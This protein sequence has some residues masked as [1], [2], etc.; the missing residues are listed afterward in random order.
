MKQTLLLVAF[1]VFGNMLFS[2]AVPMALKDW[3]TN[4]GTQTMF[5]KNVVKTD[6]SGNVYTAGAT[7]NA[8]G[9]YDILLT[10]VTSGGT[11][12]YTKTV[13]GTANEHDF[14]LGMLV[15]GT[16]VFITGAIT[17][18]TTTLAPDLF[19]AKYNSSGVQ[20]FFTTFSN[21]YG[22]VGRDIVINTTHNYI[23][24]SGA[25]YDNTLQAD[26]LAVVFDHLGNEQYNVTHDYNGLHDGAYKVTTRTNLFTITG[27]VT[28]STNNY[29]LASQT[30]S[31]LSGLPSGSITVGATATSSVEIISDLV[32]D[33]SGN[34]YICGAT[35]QN[36]GQ[37]YDMYVAKVTSSLTISWEQTINGYSGSS[38]NDFAKGIKINA[39]GDVFVTGVTTH[40]TQGKNMTT[41]KLN[42][43]GAIQWRVDE[44]GTFNGNDGGADLDMDASSNVYVTGFKTVDANNTDFYSVKYNSSGTKIWEVSEQYPLNDEGTNLVLDNNDNI[45]IAGSHEYEAGTF[46]YLTYKYDQKDILT[47]TDF[48]GETPS[49]NFMY[50][51]NSGQ[52]VD[53]NQAA[54]PQIKYYTHNTYPSFYFKD[55]NQS[56]V[57]ARIDTVAATADTLHRIDL[58]FTNSIES[59]KTYA[60]EQQENGYLNYFLAHTGSKGITG[61]KGNLRL[62]T[63][64]L[65]S[66]IDLM[67]SSNQ[68]GIKYYFIVK[69]GGDMRDIKMEFTGA[70]SYSLNGTTNHLSINSSIGSF[71][72]DKPV[73]YQLTAGNATV[74]V[75]SFSP[76]WT[77]DGAANKYK[78]ND[79]TYTS[80]L[81][82]VIEVDQGNGTSSAAAIDNLHWSTYYGGSSDDVFYDVKTNSSNNVWVTGRTTSINFPT[83]NAYQGTKAGNS[84]AVFVKFNNAGVRQWS[85]YVGGSLDEASF[86]QHGI[87]V[88]ASGNSYSA[89]K[90]TST[91]FPVFASTISGA[92]YDNSNAAV[93]PHTPQDVAII[94]LNNNGQRTW[95]TYFGG[96]GWI[97][98]SYDIGLDGNNNLFVTGIDNGFP[99]VTPSGAYQN[100]F[101]IAS[102]GAYFIA[103][104]GPNHNLIWSTFFGSNGPLIKKIGFNSANDLIIV[105]SVNTSGAY[106][107]AVD[108]GG[109]AYYDDSFDG[110]FDGFIARFSGE[111][112]TLD[113]STLYGGDEDDKVNAIIADNND[114][115]F[116][117]GETTTGT[118]LISGN[119]FGL[120]NTTYGGTGSYISLPIGDGF[121]AKFNPTNQLVSSTYFGGAANEGSYDIAYKNNKLFIPF[122]TAGDDMPFY[123]SNPST[124]FEQTNNSDGQDIT[125]DGY[126]TVMDDNYNFIWSSYFGGTNGGFGA[127]ADDQIFSNFCSNDN[128]YYIVGGTKSSTAFPLVDLGS[129]AY[130]QDT[131]GSSLDAFIA[132]FDVSTSLVS[133]KENNSSY[134]ND[135]LTIFPNP[136]DNVLYTKYKSD[137]KYTLEIIDICGRLIKRMENQTDNVLKIDISNVAKGAYIIKVSEK[138]NISIKKL[139]IN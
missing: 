82:L 69:P 15:S 29:K 26:M 49:N 72:F 18:N 77:T 92:Y 7:L 61:V 84:D 136:A 40:S 35:Q 114:N 53:T 100:S 99:I 126:F 131:K 38:G 32:T 64:E 139:I 5:Q 86:N 27:P 9:K 58:D 111:N 46:E 54:V 118:S 80:S 91:N 78:F 125:N 76:T 73:A 39:S 20:Q 95:A 34:F 12:V 55:R 123:G 74:A 110:T 57:F 127:L 135:N 134:Q 98:N 3:E 87:E 120:S 122:I 33:A 65:Y 133:V 25:S 2:Q 89:F 50:F 88:D 83:Y 28:Q 4:A 17:N 66:N 13:N 85:T 22:D 11:A 19:I 24:V 60:M 48:N 36:A 96:N 81:T 52:L 128:K 90:T 132:Q 124:V 137:T 105:G 45:I 109:G 23:I 1:A 16:D 44:N 121:L 104:F 75:T 116:I 62:V 130:Y 68:N 112:L 70:T 67:C 115:I 56:F 63:P 41:V 59:S 106:F 102:G 30:Y 21:G 113:W 37:G 51:R 97:A 129:G 94:S 107:D 8:N 6:G 93:F 43:S 117:S 108:Y 47:P 31:V 79:G 14:A 119:P 101:P 42:S 71:T 10:K 103:K 138:D